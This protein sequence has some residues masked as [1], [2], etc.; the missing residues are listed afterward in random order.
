VKVN[1]VSGIVCLLMSLSLS[2]V[3]GVY[4]TTNSSAALC[5]AFAACIALLVGVRWVA[6]SR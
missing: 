2:G 4:A 6:G 1:L 5:I 3:A